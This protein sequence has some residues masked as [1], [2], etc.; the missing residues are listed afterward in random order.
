[1]ARVQLSGGAYSARSVIAS[2]QRQV[3]LYS[4]PMP[5]AQGEP[6]PDA[7]YPTAGLRKLATIGSGPIR[8][9]RRCTNGNVYVVSG[10]GVY[11]VAAD[12]SATLL[13]N[14]TAGPT[15]PVSI[16]DNGTT[17]VVVDGSPS[18]WTIDLVSNAFAPLPKTIPQFQATAG[19]VAAA[20]TGYAVGDTLSATGGTLMPD[21]SA[22]NAKILTV[23][24]SGGVTSLD[25]PVPGSYSVKPDDPTPTTSTGPGSGCTVHLTYTDLTADSLFAG[26][27]KVDYLDTFFIFNKPST[28]QFFISGSL[29]TTF[30][31]LDFANKEAFSDILMSIAVAKKELWLI[32][33][34]TTEIWYDVGASADQASGISTGF[35]FAPMP[36][37]FID[38][39]T[40]AKY[41]VAMTDDAVYW[42]T[43]DRGGTGSILAG[44]GY[45]AKPISTYAMEVEFRSYPRLDDAI[46]YT[47]QIGGHR[48]YSIAFPHADK[49]WSYDITTSKW[50]EAVWLDTNGTEHRHRANCAF[51]AHGEVCCG[52]WENGNVYAYDL[53]T[54]TDDGQPIKR[55]RQWPHSLNEGKRVFYKQFI[56]D[57]EGGTGGGLIFP[58]PPQIFLA[59]SDDR[60]H[61]WGNPVGQDI[62]ETGDY[63]SSVQYQRLGMARDR[64]WQLQWSTPY[65]TCLQGAWIIAESAQS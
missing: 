29:D 61:S 49:T 2:A 10:S 23:D 55:L 44:S 32:G 65:K 25:T 8:G 63:V 62:G 42:L 26:A 56:A 31:P 15:T 60:G 39:G 19:T 13:G 4:E 17:A 48:F 59:W 22:I 47:H 7:L 54:F 41:S 11:A 43:Q 12:W 35:Q 9:G 28:P 16:A 24:S 21:Q 5:Q 51:T 40:I 20:G 58:E 50:H 36:G 46:G 6:S 30:D 38:R 3:N 18:G 52:D 34:Q 37:V 53:A 45:E 57:V 64:T 27:D 33:S 14:V 1:M